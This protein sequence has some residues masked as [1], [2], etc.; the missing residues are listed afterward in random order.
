M[1][2]REERYTNIPVES[3]TKYERIAV[4]ATKRCLVD[5][6]IKLKIMGDSSGFGKKQT[7]KTLYLN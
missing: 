3:L 5:L 2:I 7:N 6:G 1:I 4:I